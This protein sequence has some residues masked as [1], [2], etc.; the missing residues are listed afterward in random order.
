MSAAAA[1]EYWEPPQYSFF[2]GPECLYWSWPPVFL[3]PPHNVHDNQSWNIE[4]TTEEE[5]NEGEGE[6]GEKNEIAPI[7]KRRRKKNRRQKAQENRSHK[8]DF[9][10][11]CRHKSCAPMKCYFAHSFEELRPK[12]VPANYKTIMCRN[13]TSNCVFSEHCK[14]LHDREVMKPV[15]KC[16]SCFIVFD[17]HGKPFLKLRRWS[18]NN[19]N[20]LC[21]CFC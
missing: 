3:S 20:N 15:G 4:A 11:L 6:E 5:E 21:N 9:T 19:R 1:V 2:N 18:Y 13:A 7:Q 17:K 10:V 14:Y 12:V 16:T 8:D